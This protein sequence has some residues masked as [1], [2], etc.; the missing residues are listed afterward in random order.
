MNLKPRSERANPLSALYRLARR[1]APGESCEFCSLHLGPGHRHVLEVATHKIVCACDACAL[2]FDNVIGRFKLIPRDAR[3]LPDFQITDT[4]WESLSLPIG[5][6][7]FFKS[8]S[9]GR[10]VVMYPSPGGATESLV[11]ISGWS[12]MVQGNP[13]LEEMEPDV[14]ALLA[15]R[16]KER[17]E[18]FLAPVDVCFELV[19]IIRLSWR[20][21]SGGDEVWEQLDRFFTRLRENAAPAVPGA[22]EVA[23]A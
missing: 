2:R 15:N 13:R 20:G 16:L 22:M 7:F 21:F 9:A 18:Y 12:A 3:L 14:Q 10:I 1:T 5:L 17:R 4:K 8:T 11:P 19:G 6:A 23:G